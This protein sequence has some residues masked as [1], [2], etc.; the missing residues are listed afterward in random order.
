[1]FT[2]AHFN[3]PFGSYHCFYSEYYLDY[4]IYIPV[5]F[6]KKAEQIFYTI[7]L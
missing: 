7:E 3:T 6:H 5:V 4:A 1:M 2:S